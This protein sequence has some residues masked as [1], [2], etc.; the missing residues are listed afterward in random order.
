MEYI[1]FIFTGYGNKQIMILSILDSETTGSLLLLPIEL[2]LPVLGVLLIRTESPIRGLIYRSFLGSIAA[3]IYA[4]VGAPDVALT[5]VLVGTLLSAILYIITIR[6]CYTVLII[7][8]ENFEISEVVCSQITELF[9]ELHLQVKY[10]SKDFEKNSTNYDEILSEITLSGSPHGVLDG[11]GIFIESN[12]LL[13]NL[14]MTKYFENNDISIELF[15][16]DTYT[17]KWRSIMTNSEK[18]AQTVK[19]TLYLIAISIVML[20]GLLLRP[21]AIPRNTNQIVEYLT[22][23]TNIPNSVTAVILG[24]RLF[25]TIGEVTVFTGSRSWCKDIT[26]RRKS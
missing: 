9:N 22:T 14:K 24:S 18:R 13:Q 21:E 8:P 12:I 6:A 2:I 5:E 20:V 26:C 23:L 3:L 1:L 25:D 17:P 15:T 10:L 16:Q 4:A 19:S 7:Y 11:R